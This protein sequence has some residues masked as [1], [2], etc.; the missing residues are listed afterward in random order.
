MLVIGHLNVS[1]KYYVRVLA[2]TK[3]GRGMYS[4][5]TKKFTYA[6]AVKKAINETTRTLT[7]YLHKPV[8]NFT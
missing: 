5:S 4:N 7:F 3:I 6:E 2:S 1:T 8:V